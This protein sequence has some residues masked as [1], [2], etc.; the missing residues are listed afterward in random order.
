MRRSLALVKPT[1]GDQQTLRIVKAHPP[2]MVLFGQPSGEYGWMSNRSSHAVRGSDGLEFVSAEHYF[3]YLV[4]IL[5]GQTQMASVVLREGSRARL[6][7]LRARIPNWD[8]RKWLEKREELLVHVLDQKLRSNPRLWPKL[9]ATG[10]R[11]LVAA[12]PHDPELGIGLD[13]ADPRTANPR[14][15]LGRN[16]LGMCWIKVR[17]GLPA[18]N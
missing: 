9:R 6:G 14:L 17:A 18:H 15:W 1:H 2:N 8:Q 12:L 11:I 5:M 13:I 7:R 3:T 4:A 16:L 10:L